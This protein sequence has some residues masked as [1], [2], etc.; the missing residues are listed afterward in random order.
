M[1]GEDHAQGGQDDEYERH[2]YESGPPTGGLRLLCRMPHLEH[3]NVDRVELSDAVGI[4]V[5]KGRQNRRNR[6]LE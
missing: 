5:I 6:R 2:R 1:D 4:V 3:R